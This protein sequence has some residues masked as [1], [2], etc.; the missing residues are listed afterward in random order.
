MAPRVIVTTSR[1]ARPTTIATAR[2]RAALWKLPFVERND[3]STSELLT[4]G[5]VALMFTNSEVLLASGAGQLTFHLGTA[6]IR[7][8][9]LARGEL[10]PLIRSAEIAPGDRVLDT[11]FGLGR[12]ARVVAQTSGPMGR[13]V[14]V[15]SSAALF[16]LAQ[17][18]LLRAST[19]SAE[20]APIELVHADALA[21][22]ASC[23][24]NSFDV[25]LVDP[26]FDEPTT[27]DAGFQLLRAVAD[28]TPL[29]EQW[30]SEARRVAR[31]WVIV[32]AARSQPWF[33]N[34]ALSWV[35]SNSN[36]GWYRS[37]AT[38]TT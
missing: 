33:D 12:D 22:L 9:A 1:K 24:D 4:N 30:V 16:Y 29:T 36:A 20:A 3:R 13:V 31:R 25:V 6:Y 5:D 32:K 17:E 19:S 2:D 34:V 23:E 15:E 35:K 7:L 27:S 10:D 8:Q 38:R 18:G 14:G 28:P 26:M 11:T 21:Y 37:P